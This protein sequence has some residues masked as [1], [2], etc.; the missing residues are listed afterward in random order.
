MSRAGVGRVLACLH[1]HAG[2]IGERG[3]ANPEPVLGA[4]AYTHARHPWGTLLMMHSDL[5]PETEGRWMHGDPD[6]PWSLATL[7]RQTGD[8]ILAES[9]RRRE[10]VH[11]AETVVESRAMDLSLGLIRGFRGEQIVRDARGKL[12]AAR[13]DDWPAGRSELLGSIAVAVMAE[14]QADERCPECDGKG[15]MPYVLDEH[16][17]PV[18]C[19]A[20]HGTTYTR[21]SDRQRAEEA[22][23]TWASWRRGWRRPYEWLYAQAMAQ[24]TLAVREFRA[25]LQ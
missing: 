3:S 4:L 9:T 13:A 14:L 25:Q 24:R 16:R 19:P 23:L 11:Y 12:A 17:Q 5:D 20:C 22:R 2:W 7:R 15:V 1:P 21:W 18:P 6:S 8:R 10:A